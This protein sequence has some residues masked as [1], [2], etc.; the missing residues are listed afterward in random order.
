MEA[1][2][3]PP[4]ETSDLTEDVEGEPE[5]HAFMCVHVLTALTRDEGS[6][7]MEHLCNHLH[8][9]VMAKKADTAIEHFPTGPKVMRKAQKK[10]ESFLRD[11]KTSKRD[12]TTIAVEG[13]ELPSFQGKT[14]VP[15]HPH[16]RMVAWH[17]KHL[18][19]P[20][21]ERLH[22]TINQTLWWPDLCTDCRKWVKSCHTC[23]LTKKTGRKK[24][25]KLPPKKA[26]ELVPWN[27][28]DLDCIGPLSVTTTSVKE[29]QLKASTMIDPATGYLEMVDLPEIDSKSCV[30]AFDDVW[31]SRCPRP[32][33][34]GCNNGKKF[35]K[36]FEDMRTTHEMDP[37]RTATENPQANGITERVHGVLNDCLR[38]FE[39][40]ERELDSHQ[41]WR[42]FLS[43]TAFAIRST[44]H[45]ALEATP[46]QLVFNG[47]MFL[48]IKFTTD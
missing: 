16:G 35:K 2:F 14:A 17:H 47:D 11:L 18:V 45:T 21:A 5:T 25:G 6:L 3:G 28:V 19:H 41:P 40:D 24:H 33:H 20:G 15:C 27:R 13:T 34:L 32:Q 42:E 38:T 36:T 1:R 4:N 9:C 12:C 29:C 37:H 10:D 31:L 43:A 7:D 30:D 23:Q 46:A 44:H 8:E 39:L 26:K 22:K 48:P